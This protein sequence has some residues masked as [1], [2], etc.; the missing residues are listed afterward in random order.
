MTQSYFQA[1]GLLVYAYYT[2]KLFTKATDLAKKQLKKTQTHKK[3]FVFCGFR[4]SALDNI[5]ELSRAS[6]CL[7]QY[8]RK[9]I[10]ISTFILG[11]CL[12]LG[13]GLK[14]D[15]NQAVN[16]YKRVKLNIIFNAMTRS[17]IQSSA[18]NMIPMFV[19]YYK[20]I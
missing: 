12:E 5:D 7:P 8:I 6:C 16:L 10:A 9:G 1:M 3:K 13:L 4:V 15:P 20:I 17:F 18:S 11:R 19:N 2:R 14:K